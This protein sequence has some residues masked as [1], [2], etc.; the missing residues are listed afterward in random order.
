M[1]EEVGIVGALNNLFVSCITNVTYRVIVN[2]EMSEVFRPQCGIRQGDPLSPYIFV[3]CMEK[4]SHII[5]QK[6]HDGVWKPV[7]TSRG[8]PD[9][10]HLFFADDLILFGKASLQQAIVMREALDLFCDLSGQ[11]V[12]FP[13]S[14]IH[15]SRNVNGILAKKLEDVCGS[16]ITQ[17]LGNYLGVPLIH[18]RITRDT[19]NDIIVKTQKR[20]AS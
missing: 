3:L 7:K 18:G 15:C 2:G 17:N 4:L 10:Y 5:H 1:L 19:Y 11:Q 9:I 16:P 14:R 12:S 6:L 13:K 8:G 20:L